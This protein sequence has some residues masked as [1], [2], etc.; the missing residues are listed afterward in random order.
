MASENP[1]LEGVLYSLEQQKH[2]YKIVRHSQA[3][4]TV[5]EKRQLIDGNPAYEAAGKVIIVQGSVLAYKEKDGVPKV[6][7]YFHNGAKR[8]DFKELKRRLGIRKKSDIVF[9]QGDL[10]QLL[11]VPEGA[12]SPFILKEQDVDAICISSELIEGAKNSE[13]SY[14]V[15]I[16]TTES[17]LANIYHVYH[18]LLQ[19]IN[20]S[21]KIKII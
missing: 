3:S 21:D 11:G 17:L 8:I 9:Y 1:V 4:R 19:N 2:P 5:R 6:F 15:A 18:A 20:L 10:E 16:S 14:D 13:K 12:V 7:L